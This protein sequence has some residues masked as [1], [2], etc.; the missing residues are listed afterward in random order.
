MVGIETGYEAD[1]AIGFLHRFFWHSRLDIK[2]DPA[3]TYITAGIERHP[4]AQAVYIHLLC[5]NRSWFFEAIGCHA[6]LLRLW[7]RTADGSL[8]EL[9]DFKGPVPMRWQSTPE[10][11]PHAGQL[12]NI[13][14]L[15][16]K[17]IDFGSTLA[18]ED[19]LWLYIPENYTGVVRTLNPGKYQ[20]EVEV[21]ARNSVRRR[22]KRCFRLEF[23]DGKWR[24]ELVV[25]S[26][27]PGP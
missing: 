26:F 10:T 8:K 11:G 3:K 21:R 24:L 27:L 15:S 19:T 2:F 6:A 22:R 9:P 1:Q 25:F 18:G 12:M 20:V 17:N 7:E 13:D 4:G 14:K 16:T 23:V 5:K